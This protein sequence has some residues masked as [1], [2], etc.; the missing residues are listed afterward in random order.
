VSLEHASTRLGWCPEALAS[1]NEGADGLAAT[2]LRL[3]GRLRLR[4][5]LPRAP[6]GPHGSLRLPAASE[7]SRERGCVA[8]GREVA[9]ACRPALLPGAG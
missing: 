9:A 5:P 2:R 8:L 7:A 4:L 3:R 1:S 6:D